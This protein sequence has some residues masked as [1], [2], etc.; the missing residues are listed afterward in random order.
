ML[1]TNNSKYANWLKMYKSFGIKKRKDSQFE[2]IGS[3]L[4]MSNIKRFLYYIN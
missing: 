1:T 2:I 3:N 4:K